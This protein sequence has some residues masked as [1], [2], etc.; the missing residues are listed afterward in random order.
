DAPGAGGLKGNVEEGAKQI[1]NLAS[2]PKFEGIVVE[3]IVSEMLRL[4]KA[5]H[6]VVFYG[7]TIIE[8]CKLQSTIHPALGA[9][10][11]YLYDALPSL[12]VE[13]VDRFLEW[14]AFHL[15]NFDFKWLWAEWA[16]AANQVQN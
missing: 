5:E 3:T 11:S 7:A 2:V 14:F 4:P 8:L 6:A 12:Q 1:L 15:S 9:A 13:C 16:N 10:I